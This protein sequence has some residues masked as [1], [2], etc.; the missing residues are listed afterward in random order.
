MTKAAEL[1]KWGE[2]S[3]NGQ[4]SGRRNII[5]NGAMNVAQRGT[6]TTGSTGGGFITDRFR[7]GVTSL[8]TWTMS[9]ATDAPSGFSHSAKIECTTADASPASTDVLYFFT[10]LEGQDLQHLK[11]GTANAE[12]VTI[13]FWMKSTKTGVVTLNWRNQD[14][15]RAIGKDLTISSANTWEYHTA[16][17]LGDTAAVFTNDNG[18]SASVEI[19][20]NGGTNYTSGSTPTVWTA[21]SNTNGTRGGGT[22]LAL[23]ANTSES[24]QISGL[25]LEVGSVATPFEHR[26]VGEELQLCRRYFQDLCSGASANPIANMS[27]YSATSSHGHI[28]LGTEM[29]SIPTISVA[30]VT[31]FIIYSAG[32]GNATSALIVGGTWSRK[33]IELNATTAASTAGHSAFM[34]TN[35]TAASIQL[36]A[37]L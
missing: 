9:Q 10:R 22:T 37:E 11:F 25:Q 1:A 24:W 34:R 32:A 5:I 4:V 18:W 36:D 30:D 2:V 16:T 26:S 33:A 20:L 12:T 29:N 15:S 7:L 8:G 6:S 14:N 27:Y 35:N 23:G 31:H 13:S 17:F 28:K 19:L 21:V 3:T